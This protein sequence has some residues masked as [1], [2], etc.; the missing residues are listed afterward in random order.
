MKI[1]PIENENQLSKTIEMISIGFCWSSKKALKK[2]N[3]LLINNQSIG[4]YGYTI[5]NTEGMVVG[6]K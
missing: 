1:L 4:L 3:D 6:G 2:K 5:I